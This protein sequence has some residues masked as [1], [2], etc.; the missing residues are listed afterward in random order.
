MI[1]STLTEIEKD[2]I[3]T[4]SYFYY[5]GRKPNW[6]SFRCIREALQAHEVNGINLGRLFEL[7]TH[8]ETGQY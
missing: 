5:G 1:K 3:L 7:R 6:S 8:L 2:V 4:A